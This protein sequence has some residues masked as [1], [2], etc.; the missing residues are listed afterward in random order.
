[1]FKQIAL[2]TWAPDAPEAAKTALLGRAQAGV[3]A[4]LSVMGENAGAGVRGG[5]LVW[6]LHF[7]DRGAWEA[8]GADAA[9]DQLEGDPAVATLDSAAYPVERFVVTTPGL[10]DGVY[11]T[12]FLRYLDGA[13]EEAKRRLAEDLTHMQDYVP[14][15]LNWAANPVHHARGEAPAQFVWE[16]EFADLAG[17]RGPYMASPHHWGH[18]DAWFDPEMP[19]RIVEEATLRHSASRLGSS[20]MADYSR[21]EEKGARP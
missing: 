20:V 19:Q 10:T 9:L 18:V 14:Q 3:R 2:I 6:H 11:R 12:L 8:S 4:D 16:Q 17:L 7:A 15:I 5:D 13:P 1:M 21:F